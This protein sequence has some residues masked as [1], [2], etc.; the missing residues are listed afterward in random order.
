[1]ESRVHP[2]VIGRPVGQARFRIGSKS[3][4]GIGI[5]NLSQDGCCIQVPA[6][7][8]ADL[9]ENVVLEDWRL[10]LP[11]FQ[12]SGLKAQVVWVHGTSAPGQPAEAG[13]RFMDLS[14]RC[15]HDLEDFVTYVRTFGA[16]PTDYNGM[17]A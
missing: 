15:V 12:E 6:A 3:C 10:S 16:P 11:N 13:I 8:E 2:R 14:V 1:M 4:R 5:S 17:P 9:K 7:L